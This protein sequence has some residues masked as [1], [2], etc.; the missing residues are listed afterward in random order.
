MTKSVTPVDHVTIRFAGDSGD[1][2]QV[3]GTQ[4]T[5]E[6]AALGNVTVTFPDYPAEIRAPAGTLSGVSGFQVC[7]G[8]EDVHTPGDQL[9]VLVAMNPAA[10]KVNLPDVRPGGTILVNQDAFTTENLE[11]AGYA[12][13]PLHD[14][15]LGQ[16]TVVPVPIT[17]LTARA[18]E[19]LK[20]PR[21]QAERPRNFFALGLAL[22][23]FERPMESTHNFIRT[24]FGRDE[25]VARANTLAL[26]AGYHYGATT[27]QFTGRFRIPPA[28]LPPGRYRNLMGNQALAIGFVAAGRTAGL[29]VFYASY[30]ITPASE[31][32]HELSNL[33]EF[34][35][36]TFQAEDE[37]S[38][39]GAAI[40]ASYGGSIGITGTSGPGLSLKSE[41]INLAVMVEL[42]LVVVDVQRA[43]PSTGMPTKVEQSDLLMALHGRSGESP[44]I[45]LA[46]SSPADCFRIAMEAIRL[47]IKY[48]TPVIALSDMYLA[49][50]SEPWRVPAPEELPRI[51]LH[52]AKDP[53]TFRPYARDPETLARPWAVPG[54][55]GLEH[56]IGGLEK[57]DVTGEVSYDPENHQRMVRLRAEKIAR[58]VRDVPDVVV[59]GAQEGDLL[60]IG[61]GCPCGAIAAAA[62]RMRRAGRAVGWA[63]LTH[64]NP[65]P[66]NLGDVLRRFRKVLVPELNLGQL[67]SVLRSRYLVDA[68]P[69]PKVKGKP[70]LVRE[71][72]EGAEAVLEGRPLP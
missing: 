21:K 66:A 68:I 19:E 47:A 5:E 39:V 3:I 38:A 42:P 30:P 34:D 54:T 56:R 36:R 37:I 57:F 35:V 55:P 6:S 8:G 28:H 20:L 7:L 46:P 41:F 48:M 23:L 14:G 45:V 40:G 18:V 29:P 4:F 62:E 71:I 11:K 63:G 50:S 10:L 12:S 53:A 22:W 65:M 13:D 32:L 70:F 25:T 64:L 59:H 16:Y 67:A 49:V 72:E 27:E 69:L 26:E 33:K 60:M 52:F 43:G 24:K 44:L 58:A 51:P 9:D 17:T 61:W 31:I 2:S 1:G 15:S